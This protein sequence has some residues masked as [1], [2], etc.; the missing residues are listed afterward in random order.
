MNNKTP[1]L[2]K[3]NVVYRFVCPGC[4]ADYI[5]KTDRNMHERC[6]EYATTKSSAILDHITSCS[7][8]AYVTNL[9]RHYI[10]DITKE[11]MREYRISFVENNT[12]IIDMSLNWNVLLVKV[13][14]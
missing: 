4:S 10:N 11:Q 14:A 7:E 12:D 1:K 13:F 3:S 9:L 2:L 6:I 8:F 5:G